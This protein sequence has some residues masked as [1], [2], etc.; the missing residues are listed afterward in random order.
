MRVCSLL[1]VGLIVFM[2]IGLTMCRQPA[3]QPAETPAATEEPP[4]TETPQASGVD[5]PEAVAQQVRDIRDHMRKARRRVRNGEKQE[6]SIEL[7]E[8]AA[9][10]AQRATEST[11][12]VKEHLEFSASE[13]SG[14]AER[15]FGTP[16]ITIEE[17]DAAMTRAFWALAGYH[18]TRGADR[19]ADGQVPETAAHLN[20]SAMFIDESIGYL[21]G[22]R[23]AESEA[24]V[25]QMRDVAR[26]LERGVSPGNANFTAQIEDFGQKVKAYADHVRERI[27]LLG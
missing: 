19:W 11:G 22:Q 8:A 27:A 23:E 5:A 18:Y 14:M 16:V 24:L 3:E 21:A 17:M 15:V 6:A 10:Y 25:L 26:Q 13:F 1:Q 20:A 9:V 2:A 12:Q 7:S 4:A